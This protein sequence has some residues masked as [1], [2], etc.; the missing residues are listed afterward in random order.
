MTRPALTDYDITPLGSLYRASGDYASITIDDIEY[1]IGGSETYYQGAANA[2]RENAVALAVNEV[3]R[4]LCGDTGAEFYGAY[5]CFLF[6]CQHDEWCSE[7]AL[8][9]LHSVGIDPGQS[10]TGTDIT[11]FVTTPKVR[12]EFDDHGL[13]SE[14]ER[15]HTGQVLAGTTRRR[16]TTCSC[17]AATVRTGATP[18]SWSAC[19]MTR[20]TCTPSRGTPTATA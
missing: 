10:L 20:A 14:P 16:A 5:Y 15:D 18:A 7:F 13:L 8:W 3:R 1:S 12:D 4:G 2:A 6:F 9:I 17:A 11:G 19:P